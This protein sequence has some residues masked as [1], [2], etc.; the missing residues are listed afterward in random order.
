MEIATLMPADAAPGREASV[1]EL[2]DGPSGFDVGGLS[3]RG[4]VV[5]M[6]EARRLASRAQAIELAAVAEL[7]RRRLAEGDHSCDD[8]ADIG[9]AG[10][11]SAGPNGAG[12]VVGVVPPH[13]YLVDEVAEVLTLTSA[14][15]DDLIRFATELTSRLPRT[16]AALGSGDIDHG[17]ARTLWRGTDQVGADLA[18]VIEAKV[19]P[20]ASEQT[21]G[22]IRAKIRRLIRRL[23]RQALTRRREEAEK[24][25]GVRLVET[26]TGTADLVG[27][28]LPVD[29]AGAAYGRVSAIAAGL[30]SDGDQRGIDQLRADV[31]LALLRGTLNTTQPPADTTQH[32]RE[33]AGPSSGVRPPESAAPVWDR[34]DDAVADVIAEAARAELAALTRARLDLPELPERHHQIAV[35]IAQAGARITDSLAV[36]RARWCMPGHPTPSDHLPDHHLPGHLKPD[37]HL[38]G[39]R[40]PAND[41]PGHDRSARPDYRAF[42]HRASGA[43][44]A[45]GHAA[46]GRND[47]V[48]DDGAPHWWSGYRPP[49]MMRRLVEN[50]DRRCCFPGCR[51]PVRHCDADHS[52]P[53]HR[54]GPTCPCNLAMLCRH[55]H[56]LKQTPG[57][58]IEHIW[59]G[60]ILW[61]GPTGH[62]RITAPADRE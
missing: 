44:G 46:T 50:R 19:L 51:R 61:I 59:P 15:A 38:P 1:I 31:F 43:Y 52:V 27:L 10:P 30:K 22:Q 34:V 12:P 60:V 3:D 48:H 37:R 35:L 42:A 16:F 26:D 5:A 45:S 41:E 28:D 13:E 24:Q 40:Q 33:P 55:H 9:G 36:L 56:R 21:T 53:F 54:G 2:W 7:A 58:R 17:K 20:K 29:A 57:W 62:W 4:L 14:S 8:S 32:P 11:N 23:D 18:E 47:S 25:R 6:A 39:H 49:A